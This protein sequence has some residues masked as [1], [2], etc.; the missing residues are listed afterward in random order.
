M[1]SKHE[2]IV[3][4]CYL[5]GKETPMGSS[6]VLLHLRHHHA[7]EHARIVERVARSQGG[8]GGGAAVGAGPSPVIKTEPEAI[9][10]KVEIE[11]TETEPDDQT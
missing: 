7:P 4:R 6:N 5:C 8:G 9:Q 10:I 1:S 11:E 3:C 2:L